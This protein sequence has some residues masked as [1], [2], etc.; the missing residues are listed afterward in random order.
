MYINWQS[1]ELNLK[2]VYYGPAMSGK[3]TNLESIHNSVD[4]SRRSTLI[5]LKTHEDRTLFFDFLQLDLGRVGGLSPKIQLY[6]VPGQAYYEAS[7][8][9][10]L[11][12]ADGVVFVADSA[13]ARIQ[14]NAQ[15]WR[16]MMEH[17]TSLGISPQTIPII[18]QCNKQ[19]LP[20][21]VPPETMRRTLRAE[22]HLTFS[23]IA[24]R[25]S[26]V[27]ETFKAIT[28]QVMSSVQAQFA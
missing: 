12:G 14:D 24:I 21:A 28:R 25:G 20:S 17:L 13:Q 18:L 22:S 7:R 11:R 27:R 3:T 8:K 1:R 15:A 19:D 4:P 5:S 10:V 2:V 23:A 6:T 16:K 26:G 9:L